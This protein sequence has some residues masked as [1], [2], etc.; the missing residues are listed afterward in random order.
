VTPEAACFLVK[1][2]D[3]LLKAQEMLEN[4]P[5]EAGRASYLAAFHAAQALIF[6]STGRVVRPRAEVQ[7]QFGR[8][9]R[10]NSERD[11]GLPLFLG[12]AYNLK[13]IAD[14]AAEPGLDIAPDHAA[15]FVEQAGR[16]VEFVAWSLTALPPTGA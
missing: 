9:V 7:A 13:V 2:R 1:A 15:L 6:E 16:I 12:R 4:W 10:K 14:D 8:L 5:D 3:R 11:A